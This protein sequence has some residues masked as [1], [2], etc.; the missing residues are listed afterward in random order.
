MPT[1]PTPPK[2]PTAEETLRATWSAALSDELDAKQFTPKQ[3]HAALLKA[4]A[5][6]TIQAVYSWL[7]GSTAPSPVNQ[8]YCAH[9]LRAPAHRLFPLPQVG[10][11]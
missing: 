7:S 9:V 8:A 3:F 6:V 11:A 2:A 1:K 10:A 5:Q 4:G